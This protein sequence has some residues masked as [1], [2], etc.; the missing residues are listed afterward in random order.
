MAESV[1]IYLRDIARKAG[2]A[3]LK[4]A[5]G[6]LLT[7][8]K[9]RQPS[10]PAG[11]LPQNA[12]LNFELGRRTRQRRQPAFGSRPDGFFDRWSR[13]GRR[14]GKFPTPSLANFIH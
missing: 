9:P 8:S 2:P 12:T 7:L 5:H 3:C 4:K 11:E 1:Q 10:D 6:T 13:H 14:Y